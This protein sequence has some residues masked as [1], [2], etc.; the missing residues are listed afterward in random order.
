MLTFNL[1]NYTRHKT[2][3]CMTETLFKLGLKFTSESIFAL[4]KESGWNKQERS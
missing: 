3:L 4:F 1:R 2:N